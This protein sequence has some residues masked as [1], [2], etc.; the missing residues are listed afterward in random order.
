MMYTAVALLLPVLPA[1]RMEGGP[2]RKSMVSVLR[3]A[4]EPPVV[5]AKNRDDDDR[6]LPV[7]DQ[8]NIQKSFV[9][10]AGHKSLEIDNV[11][12]SIEG[13]GD[14]AEKGALTVARTTRGETKDKREGAKKELT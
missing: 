11:W 5:S 4:L 14:T 12:G 7:S 8:E 2:L 3:A 1:R 13:G 9:V 6:D 10:P